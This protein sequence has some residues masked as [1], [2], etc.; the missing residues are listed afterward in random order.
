MEPRSTS[1]RSFRLPRTERLAA[2]AV[3]LHRVVRPVLGLLIALHALALDAANVPHLDLNLR[4]DASRHSLEASGT[5][6]V[7]PGPPVHVLLRGEAEAV[8]FVQDE[9][10]IAAVRSG[11]RPT[12]MLR[13]SVQ[14]GATGAR[15][16]FSYRLALRVLDPALDHRQVLGIDAPM[17]G[18]EGA[19]LP[20][21]TAWHPQ[22]EG[23]GATHRLRVEAAGGMR[24]LATG[25]LVEEA[26]AGGSHHAVFVSSLP[27]PAID[28]LAGP[29]VVGE[30]LVALAPER[31]ARVRTYFHGELKDLSAAYLEA[32]GRHLARFDRL[33]GPHLHGDYSIVSAPLPTGFGM[34]GIAYLGRQVLRLPFIPGTSL[35][36]EVLHDWWG[37]GVQPAYAHGNWSEGLTTFLADYA[38]REDE[39]VEPARLMREGWL[40]DFAALTAAQDRP[41]SAFV[42]RR[43]GADQAVGYSKAAFVFFMLRD[44]IGEPAFLAGLR[45]FW[46]RYAGRS[47][48]WQDLRLAFEEA[49]GRELDVFFRQW[50][51]RPGAPDV[52]IAGAHRTGTTARGERVRI[53]IAQAGAPFSLRVPVRVHLVDGRSVDALAELDTSRAH[54]DVDVPSRA[55]SVS[56]DPEARIFRRVDASEVAPVM[57]PVIL[58]P[59]TSVVVAGDPGF[60]QAA[61]AVAQA[62]M[63]HPPRTLEVEAAARG[64]GPLFVA[65]STTDLPKLL[66]RLGL[67]PVP[68]R[69]DRPQAAFAY[70]GRTPAGRSFVAASA[71]DAA[72]LAQLAR[73]LPHLGAQSYAVF[74]GPR[75]VER[76]VWPSA[77]RRVP[78]EGP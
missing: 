39:G 29:Y 35:G 60:V 17:A 24:A 61:L 67:P 65:A 64:E 43:H 45:G 3:A 49:A 72:A 27:L 18:P 74:Q 71:P 14:P 4:I 12:G 32:A 62:T 13:W 46:R 36:H 26:D 37:N 25:R 63:E 38:F 9:R 15:V 8:S 68:A 6:S 76:G 41:L 56:L 22:L 52:R 73:P 44:A 75:S 31:T 5:L 34:P 69:L 58:D 2:C 23:R 1:L 33:L 77:A 59:R 70:A 47:A 40:R 50:V 7:P 51:S 53:L 20:G 11:A 54:V 30:R 21:G 48:S 57:R 55:A 10:P 19:F 66:A 16:A 28:L 42:S 78:V